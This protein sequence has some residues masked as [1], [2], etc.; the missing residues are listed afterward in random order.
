M[1]QLLHGAEQAT[2]QPQISCQC[3]P[4]YLTPVPSL[5][6]LSPSEYRDLAKVITSG[7]AFNPATT[8]PSVEVSGKQLKCHRESEM[9]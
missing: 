8:I 7:E 9:K 6:Y 2:T 3:L 4:F 5:L 1:P